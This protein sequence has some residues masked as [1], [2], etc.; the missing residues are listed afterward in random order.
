M[1]WKGLEV[2]DIR[3]YNGKTTDQTVQTIKEL[4]QYYNCRRSNI[5][6]DSD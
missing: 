2:V 1:V 5:C 3:S 4:E 6:I